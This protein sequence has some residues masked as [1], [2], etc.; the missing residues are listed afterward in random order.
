MGYIPRQPQLKSQFKYLLLLFQEKSIFQ[1]G[2]FTNRM[3][4][5]A[6]G[7]SLIGQ[8]LVI[9]FPPLQAVFQTES[10]YLSGE[11]SLHCSL[12]IIY[13]IHIGMHA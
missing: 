12:M 4:L 8:L 11:I 7:G 1:I 3:F 6:V 5:L 9:Y 13:Q 10:L 2:F